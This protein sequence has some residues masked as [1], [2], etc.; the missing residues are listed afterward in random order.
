[1]SESKSIS[2]FYILRSRFQPFT[3]YHYDAIV[4]LIRDNEKEFDSGEAAIVLAVVRD[5]E[6]L[7]RL[8]APEI[9]LKI[10]HV[11]F[12]HLP[13]FNPLSFNDIVLDIIEGNREYLE[14]E[15]VKKEK[16]FLEKI[17][18]RQLV[19]V[20]LRV[21]FSDLVEILDKPDQIPSG[22][23]KIL[24]KTNK[25]L[26]KLFLI[27]NHKVRDILSVAPDGTKPSRTWCIPIFDTEDCRD[28]KKARTIEASESGY[29]SISFSDIPSLKV[30]SLTVKALGVYG[31]F[32][33]CA[34]AEFEKESKD[35]RH[36][37][38]K[39]I[40]AINNMIN[41]LALPSIVQRFKDRLAIRVKDL[42][43]D[44]R[45]KEKDFYSDKDSIERN[46]DAHMIAATHSDCRDVGGKLIIVR[47]D[48]SIRAQ[49][50]MTSLRKLI[51]EK[52]PIIE[53]AKKEHTSGATR[54]FIEAISRLV[55]FASG[56]SEPSPHISDPQIKAVK[57]LA[58][59]E[60]TDAIKELASEIDKDTIL[61][62][63]NL[64]R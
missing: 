38:T 34:I 2:K 18:H 24:P 20:P 8:Y 60:S 54:E 47:G 46:F 55:E 58:G 5:Y 40:D 7:Y 15:T 62:I 21:K 51:E 32:A 10:D 63:Q 50:F 25:E 22:F 57:A 35:G 28:G 43:E 64:W 4:S 45:K 39:D 49:D 61:G 9:E 53:A 59:C 12:R 30:S 3:R 41:A 16:E 23:R 33:L 44:K 56:K 42:K 27:L 13:L 52:K 26:D 17:L 1:M 6:T 31:I 37:D 48:S 19:I 14:R 11:D 36:L 29:I